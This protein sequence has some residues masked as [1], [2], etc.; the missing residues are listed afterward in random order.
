MIAILVGW[1]VLQAPGPGGPGPQGGGVAV[2]AAEESRASAGA[3]PVEPAQAPR[4]IE[5]PPFDGLAEGLVQLQAATGEGRTEVALALADA[6]LAP[7]AWARLRTAL[8]TEHAWLRRG[9][10]WVEPVVASLGL[11]GPSSAARAEVHYAAGVA[12]D[13][14]GDPERARERFRTAL[15]LA[16][17]GELRLDAGYNLGAIALG[18][19]ERLR[20]AQRQAA[21]APQAPQ[22]VPA[23]ADPSA[24]LDR[25]EGAYRAAKAELVERLRADWRDEDLRANLELIQRRLREIAA[26]REQMKQ[27]QQQPQKSQQEEQQQG[28]DRQPS[29]DQ[30]DPR[31]DPSSSEAEREDQERQDEQQ[32]ERER[33]PSDEQQRAEQQEQRPGE[34]AEERQDEQPEAPQPSQAK[35]EERVLTRE[36]VLRI[37]SQLEEIEK[38]GQALEARLRRARRASAEKDW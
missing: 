1:L 12:L 29:Q 21:Q 38:E 4:E 24:E 16:G 3:P 28:D 13:R 36:E 14:G 25:L 9:L 34:Q 19:A 7:N 31:E 33:Q 22:V 17:P 35:S 6:L 26:Q 5:L 11:V 30:Q 8:E 32:G 37:L 20:G 10:E 23:A 27:Q 18:L 15:A 2:P